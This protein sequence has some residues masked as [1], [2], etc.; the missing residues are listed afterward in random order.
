M[1]KRN[2]L[3]KAKEAMGEASL[4][5]HLRENIKVYELEMYPYVKIVKIPSHFTFLEDILPNYYPS[6]QYSGAKESFHES[7]AY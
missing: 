1:F 3:P 2:S 6:W 5:W 4:H 7:H